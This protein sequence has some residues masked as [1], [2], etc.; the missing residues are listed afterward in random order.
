MMRGAKLVNKKRWPLTAVAPA[1]L[2]LAFIFAIPVFQVIRTSLSKTNGLGEPEEFSGF[3]NFTKLFSDPIFL[4]NMINTFVWTLGVLIP[5]TV[6]SIAVALLLDLKL[7]GNLLY[8]AVV[9]MPWAIC[10]VFI[11]IIWQYIYDQL[12]GPLNSLFAL[13]MNKDIETAWLGTPSLAMPSIIWVGITLT[14]PFTTLVLLA[15][16]Q[17]IPSEVLEAGTCDG[18]NGIKMFFYIKLPILKPVLNVVTLV[19]LLAIFNSFPIIWTMTG[20]GPD[21]ETD[22]FP[23][24]LYQIAFG[25]YDFGKAGALSVIGL[26]ILSGMSFL[27]LRKSSVSEML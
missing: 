14:I 13:I 9:F 25:D 24:Y 16:L 4:P 20:G 6:L 1:S 10:F 2:F 11:A 18:A 22:T 23:T 5:A 3:D 7:P 21:H 15:G 19:N 17:S 8:R 27:Y 12:F 26:L